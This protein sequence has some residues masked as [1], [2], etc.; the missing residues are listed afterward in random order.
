MGERILLAA[1]AAVIL[2]GAF[3]W[4]N[5]MDKAAMTSCL[6]EHSEAVCNHILHR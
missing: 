6:K 1:V 4:G 5:E 3:A 2:L